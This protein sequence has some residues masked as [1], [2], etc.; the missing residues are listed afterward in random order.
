MTEANCLRAQQD[1]TSPV[2]AR[3]ILADLCIVRL[4]PA[5]G[6]FRLELSLEE[7]ES[8]GQS[9]DWQGL[10]EFL[11]WINELAKQHQ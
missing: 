1:P 11:N 9:G 4:Y 7:T 8:A 5:G 6:R 2:V 10:A 3:E